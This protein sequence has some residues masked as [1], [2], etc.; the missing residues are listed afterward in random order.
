MTTGKPLE[1]RIGCRR[2]P[3]DPAGNISLETDVLERKVP[4]K[5]PGVDPAMRIQ[6]WRSSWRNKNKSFVAREGAV[7]IVVEIV[8]LRR[9]S[10]R[11]QREKY[12]DKFLRTSLELE[13]APVFDLPTH[14]F[15]FC[16]TGFPVISGADGKSSLECL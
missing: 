14:K 16:R 4:V 2:H 12:R 15:T 8:M 10:A 13:D 6:V 9:T 1:E 7:V 11:T 5:G 3:S